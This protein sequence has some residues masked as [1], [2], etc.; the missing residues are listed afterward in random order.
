MSGFVVMGKNA[1]GQF[2]DVKLNATNQLETADTVLNNKLDTLSGAG[3]NNIGDGATKLQTYCYGRDATN[4]QMK[5]LKLDT[6]GRLECSVDALEVT[7]ETI[8]LSTDTL[9][10]LITSTNT[11]LDTIETSADALISANHTDLVA[12]EASLTSMEGKQDTVITHIDGVEGKLDA[13]EASLTSM[14]GKQD[15]QVTHLSEIEGA[16]E[17]IEACVNSNKVDVNIASGNITGFATSANQVQ[18]QGKIDILETSLQSMELKQDSLISANHTDLVALEASLTAMEGKQDVQVTHLSEI[19]GAVE[20][21]EAC[22]GSSKMNVNISSGGT[23]VSGI[24]THAKQDTIIGHLDGVEGKLDTIETSCDALISANHTDLVALEASLTAME[25]KQDTQVTH[26]SEIE[27]AVETLEACV[28]SNKVNVNISSGNI[29]GFSTSSNQTT[30]IGLLDS[31]RTKQ[32]TQITHLSEIEGAVETLEGCVGS[33]KVNVNISSGNITGFATSANQ[34]TTQGKLDVLETSLTSMEAKQDTQVTHLSEIEGAVETLEGCVGSNK[35]NVNISSGNISGF[36]TSANQASILTKNTEI[37]TA[38]DAM[39]AKLPA[40]LGQKANASSISTCRSSTAGAYDMSGRTTIAT[41]STTTK[42][43]C[44]SDGHLQVDVLSGGGSTDVSALSTHAKQD[45]MIT[46]LSEIEGA[47]E[48]IEGCVGSNKVNV[49]ISSG[50]ISGFSTSAK[51]D[52][53][54][55]HL[56]GVEGKL[57][58]LEASL[59]AMEGKQ[60]TQ[61]T[62]LS[63]IEGAVETLE[64]CVGAGDVLNVNIESGN[65]SGFATSANQSTTQG[66]IDTI[67]AVLDASLVKQTAIETLITSTNSKIDILDGVQDNALTKLTEID[68]AVDVVNVILNSIKSDTTS[69]ETA[70]EILDDIA[71]TEDTAHSTGDKGVMSLAVRKDTQASFGGTDGDYVPLQVNATGGLRVESSVSKTTIHRTTARDLDTRGSHADWS[72]DTGTEA[73]FISFYIDFK[74]GLDGGVAKT[75]VQ[76]QYS[77]SQHFSNPIVVFQ[78]TGITIPQYGL[79]GTNYRMTQIELKNP[80][81][82]VRIFND[83]ASNAIGIE[84]GIIIHGRE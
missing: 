65:I 20:A 5:P 17:T 37:D 11:K 7:A 74:D 1:S 84:R 68:S 80:A 75:D 63:E 9:E 31:V 25:G 62:H 40:S 30:I 56:D 67:D 59:T 35:V 41:A 23:D 26:L 2:K 52:T 44:D 39:S 14:E 48:T 8:N 18:T 78:G 38:V 53:I 79:N 71:L 70:V 4:G 57:D 42:L 50:N 28:G 33:N 64:A 60:D 72:V 36:A 46:H 34:S 83:N 21:I 43:L 6:S 76:V 66:K 16:V 10:V 32:D 81:R 82:Y 13:L 49:N 45:T 3:N 15:V 19:E 27:G 22:V 61:V 69:I 12:L 77:Q 24:S 54:I 58:V 47:V 51:Q 55:G 73:N 29:T